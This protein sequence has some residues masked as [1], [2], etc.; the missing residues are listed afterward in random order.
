DIRVDNLMTEP[1]LLAVHKGHR[2]AGHDSVDLAEIAGDPVVLCERNWAPETYDA[3]TV[4]CQKIGFSP[5]VIYH[6]PQES[7]ALLL[8][9]AGAAVTFV[10]TSARTLHADKLHFASL[11]GVDLTTSLAL[12]TRAD[13]HIASVRLLR[14]RALGL[15]ASETSARGHLLASVGQ[16]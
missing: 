12:I 3:L 4:A 9:S 1:V 13:E 10:P 8:A 15:A 14:K 11:A 6:A 5:R 7:C 2:L 16:S